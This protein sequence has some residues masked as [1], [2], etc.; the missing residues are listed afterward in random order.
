MGNGFGMIRCSIDG[1]SLSAGGGGIGG[2]A[3]VGAG[4]DSLKPIRFMMIC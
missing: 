3:F 1:D 4:G 2:V